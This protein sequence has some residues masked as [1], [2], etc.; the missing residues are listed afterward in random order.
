MQATLSVS[1]NHSA[2]QPPHQ[3]KNMTAEHG[4]HH[5]QMRTVQRSTTPTPPPSLLALGF[6]F[7]P[8]HPIY[9]HMPTTPYPPPPQPNPKYRYGIHLFTSSINKRPRGR[10]GSHV[11]Q[12]LHAQGRAE[13]RQRC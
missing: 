13:L 8:L 12:P 2:M 9:D 5:A 10:R 6:P 3:Q 11:L 1:A 4:T 7:L